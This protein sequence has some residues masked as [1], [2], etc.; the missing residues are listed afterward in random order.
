MPAWGQHNPYDPDRDPLL[1]EGPEPSAPHAVYY[2]H[3]DHLGT[4]QALTDEQGRLA[5]EMDYRARGEAREVIAEA[6]AS[7]ASATPSAS[8][9]V[10]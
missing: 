10:P 4:P 8:G 3:A 9:A 7:A 6:A 1:K 5:L 2:Y